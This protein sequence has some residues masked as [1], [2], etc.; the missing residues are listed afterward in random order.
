[1]TDK[2]VF[3]ISCNSVTIKCKLLSACCFRYILLRVLSPTLF[4]RVREAAMTSLME[5]SILVASSAP[6]VLVPEL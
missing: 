2:T 5:L 1:M 6:D 3:S 4:D